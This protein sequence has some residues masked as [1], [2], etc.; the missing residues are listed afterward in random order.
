MKQYYSAILSA[1]RLRACYD[2]APPRTKQYLEAELSTILLK[3]FPGM[4]VL[5]MGCGYGRILKPL[6]TRG[7][8]AVGIDTSDAS[9]R[10]AK[11]QIESSQNCRLALMD[12][13]STGFSSRVFDLTICAQN[14]ISAF[15]VDRVSL[16]QEAVRVTKVGGTVLFSSYA[17]T[18]W[19][20]RLEW[21]EAQAAHRLIGPIDYESTRDGVIVCKDGFH[22]STLDAAG[23]RHLALSVNQAPNIYEVDDSSIFCEIAVT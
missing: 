3:I 21:F 7:C 14:G 1:E 11:L 9:L 18:F 4:T 5:E 8:F 20:H 22:A 17:S 6:M 23:F 19:P 16:F 15:H 13:V 12:A 2:V 10:L